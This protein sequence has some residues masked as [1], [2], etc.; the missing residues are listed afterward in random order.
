[1]CF[2]GK[3]FVEQPTSSSKDQ[4]SLVDQHRRMLAD[5]NCYLER[6]LSKVLDFGCGDG[7][8]VYEYRDRGFDAY[9]FEIRPAPVLRQGEDE[10]RFGLALTGKPADVPEF[11]VSASAY[12]IPFPDSFFDFIFSTSTLEHVQD[13]GL[14]FAETA[15]VLKPGG[16][17]IHTFPARYRPIE[18]HMYVPLGGAIQSYLWFLLWACVGVRNEFQKD[19]APVERAKKN[20][21]YSRSGLKYPKLKDILTLARAHY[22]DV[23]I[24]ARSWERGGH[25]YIS[26]KGLLLSLPFS[27]RYYGSLYSRMDTVVLFLQK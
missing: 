14:A 11:E 5:R 26:F 2:P 6:G 22:R 24:V 10:K 19:M 17:A 4:F 1:M 8:H 16:V 13:H 25:G 3:E 18:P 20:F 21:H 15:R 7:R 12:K 9:G 27:Q 23:D